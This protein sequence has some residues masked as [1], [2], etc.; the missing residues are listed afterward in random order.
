MSLT[1]FNLVIFFEILKK[2]NIEIKIIKTFF[3]KF[4]DKKSPDNKLNINVE[5]K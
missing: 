4:L 3:E 1:L 2:I 5:N